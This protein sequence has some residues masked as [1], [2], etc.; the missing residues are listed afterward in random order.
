MFIQFLQK[1]KDQSRNNELQ[2]EV[3]LALAERFPEQEKVIGSILHDLEKELMRE[4]ILTEGVRLDGRN[5]T[6]IR[7]ITSGAW[8]C[9][10]E[11]MALPCLPE[12]KLKA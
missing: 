1:K 8:C 9:C 3:T 10:L 11:L 2:E 7:P 6:Q 12:A 5:T 4:R